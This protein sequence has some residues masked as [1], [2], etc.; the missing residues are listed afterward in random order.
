V[1]EIAS[2]K[3]FKEDHREVKEGFECGVKIAGF[4][5]IKEGDI[6]ESFEI[7]E[8]KRTLELES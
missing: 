3:R 6:I 8:E 4:D 2:L 5:D 1:G 7:V